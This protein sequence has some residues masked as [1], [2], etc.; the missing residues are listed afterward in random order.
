LAVQVEE[1]SARLLTW[2]GKQLPD[3]LKGQVDDAKQSHV[4]RGSELNLHG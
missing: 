4:G 2:G 1:I 3:L